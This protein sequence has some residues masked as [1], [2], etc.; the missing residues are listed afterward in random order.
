MQ[1]ANIPSSPVLCFL[2]CVYS[3][4]AY[5]EGVLSHLKQQKKRQQEER[6]IECS[7][8]LGLIRR[9][10]DEAKHQCTSERVMPVH[11]HRGSECGKCMHKFKRERGLA[12]HRCSTSVLQE[13]LESQSN[14]QSMNRTTAQTVKCNVYGRGFNRLGYLIG[15]SV[16]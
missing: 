1:A 10:A 6:T 12:V 2:P 15:T 7:I 9:A 8:Y 3:N 4:E 14:V 11:D 16:K 13:E 5:N